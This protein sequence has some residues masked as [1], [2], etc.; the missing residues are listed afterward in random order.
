MAL[1]RLA[2]FN[3]DELR[4]ADFEP[5]QAAG[6]ER[7][8]VCPKL[9]VADETG[10]GK[11]VQILGALA[12]LAEGE[13]LP[14]TFGGRVL[15]AMPVSLLRYWQSQI[16]RFVPSLTVRVLT[17]SILSRSKPPTVDETFSQ[18][19][20]V[21]Y[22]TLKSKK[23]LDD[24]KAKK[25]STVILDE[26]A[27]LK[28]E[29]LKHAAIMQI[30]ED[31]SRI[32]VV[33]ATLLENHPMELYA[34]LKAMQVPGLPPSREEWSDRFVEWS[35]GYQFETK[36]GLTVTVE[37]KP[38]G[39]KP[40]TEEALRELIEPYLLRRSAVDVGLALPPVVRQVVTIPLSPAQ[41]KAY[42]KAQALW[43]AG[44]RHAAMEKACE[45]AGDESC[46][47]QWL[48][49]WCLANP[50]KKAIVMAEHTEL[51]KLVE[52]QLRQAGIASLFVDG[53]VQQ[54]VR[55][56]LVAAFTHDATVQVLLASEVLERGMDGLQ[57]ATDT[58]I[59]IA[60]S[61]NPASIQQAE[62]RLKRFG[63]PFEKIQHFL[64][65][66]DTDHE[67]AKLRKLD[68]KSLQAALVFGEE[69]STFAASSI[70]SE[71]KELLD[72]FLDANVG[73]SI[74]EIAH[75]ASPGKSV[76]QLDAELLALVSPA[77][78]ASPF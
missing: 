19:E 7:M 30:A 34:L 68:D 23:Y 63:S 38:C 73:W 41:A 27:S 74:E 76:A 69:A 58:L 50:G 26:A 67:R 2:L 32:Y 36:Y 10:L 70:D 72:R 15:V 8:L 64:V 71:L 33:S 25:F 28:A 65:V 18:V 56:K 42:E 20:L 55:G 54:S 45:Y 6:I 40:G 17:P 22:E 52:G 4:N 35:E 48:V 24:F 37:P 75:L 57:Y 13:G 49:E 60:S 47:A 62:G 39:L 51:L 66:A 9:V 43:A 61:Y 16:E 5:Y 53:K 59:T 14:A 31:A 21:G 46:K 1:E 12:S 44:K 3:Y 77:S 78:R 11:T 29:G